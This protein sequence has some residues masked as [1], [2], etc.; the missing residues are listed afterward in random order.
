VRSLVSRCG[1]GGGEG[2]NV[3]PGQYEIK[4]FENQENTPY[5]KTW[6]GKT[7]RKRIIQVESRELEERRTG[8][9]GDA[10]GSLPRTGENTPNRTRKSIRPDDWRKKI[11]HFGIEKVSGLVVNEIDV[12][13]NRR[14]GGGFNSEIS[15]I[16][17]FSHGGRKRPLRPILPRKEES[18]QKKKGGDRVTGLCYAE[19]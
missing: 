5:K 4:N 8:C 2:T 1:E 10:G 3:D 9:E 18:G 19:R 7:W 15:D 12:K 16:A 17:A 6:R 11:E 14:L 13:G